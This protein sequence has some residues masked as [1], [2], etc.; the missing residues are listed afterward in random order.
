M[1]QTP[2][3]PAISVRF[4]TE[5]DLP[6]LSA[7]ESVAAKGNAQ[8]NLELQAA[9]DYFL[10]VGLVGDEIGGNVVLDCRADNDLRPEMKNLWVYPE[11]RRQGLGVAMT[12]FMEQKAAELGFTEIFLGVTPDNPAAIPMYI[13]LDY[14]PTGE[15][16][17]AANLAV[18][19]L[20]GDQIINDG[21]TEAIFRKSLLIRR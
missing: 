13:G 9:G 2:S 14:T 1:P 19:E 17:N 16:R 4:A 7:K 6:V 20:D 15:H 3:A 21:P 12:S 11:S 10:V 5:D 8:R 18:L